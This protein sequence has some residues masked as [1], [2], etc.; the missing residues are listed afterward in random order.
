MSV[1]LERAQAALY[2]ANWI[3]KTRGWRRYWVALVADRHTYP[4]GPLRAVT[5]HESM[6]LTCGLFHGLSQADTLVCGRYGAA[7]RD[8]TPW[9]ITKDY[10][11]TS[12]VTSVS[13]GV[14]LPVDKTGMLSSVRA[15]IELSSTEENPTHVVLGCLAR[16]SGWPP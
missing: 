2:E 3:G 4:G 5:L 7:L 11:E 1:A 16:P 10:D 6:P 12:P 13:I 15:R 14:H 8:T 9:D